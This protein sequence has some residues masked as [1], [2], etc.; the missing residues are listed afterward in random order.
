MTY[1]QIADFFVDIEFR[2]IA[3]LKRNLKKHTDWEV[4]EG[5][6]WTAWQAEKLKNIERFRKENKLIQAEYTKLITPEVEALM[7][8]QFLEGEQ[9]VEAE[10]A[11]LVDNGAEPPIKTD[12]FFG[13]NENRLESLIDEV[14]SSLKTAQTAPLRLLDDVYRKTILK[15]EFA[16]SAGATTLP[17]AVDIATKEFLKQGL[18]CIEYKNGRLVNIA[19]YAEMALRTAAVRSYLM[20]EAKKRAEIGVDTVLVSQYG[21]CSETC[22]PWQGR[23]YIDDVWGDFHGEVIGERGKSANSKWYML[24]SVAIAGGLF[25]PNCRHTLSTWF[26]GVSAFP[27]PLDAQKN[28][29]HSELEARQ[30]Q[31]E[32]DVRTWKR[33]AEGTLEPDMAK[34]YQDKAKLAQVKLR[35]FVKAHSDTLRRDYWR[36]QTMG[37][38]LDNLKKAKV[39]VFTNGG[40]SGIVKIQGFSDK[41]LLD[42]HL[43][44]H[45]K[46]YENFSPD[47]YVARA[48]ELLDH[49]V[50]SDI[51]GFIGNNDKVY[52]YDVHNNDFAVKNKSG[53]IATLFKP[54]QGLT[55]WERQVKKYGGS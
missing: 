54:K 25:H 2:L 24:L 44:K 47:D 28:K 19:S 20:G 4:K 34:S 52:R 5:F 37:V 46:E 43:D 45:L 38:P 26:E 36:E 3:S 14:Q 55:Y 23:V 15:A 22:Q 50:D 30:R 9:Q 39:K 53:T 33:M 31:L 49:P 32:R 7:Q 40:N 12:S 29:E 51:K 6:H 16:M 13:V 48:I 11:K 21:A 41:K 42:K 10:L 1:R 17:K 8:E 18:N 27:K 35:D